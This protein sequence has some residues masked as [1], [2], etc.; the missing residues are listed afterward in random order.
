[1]RI[2][3]VK[4]SSL[5][6]IV[7]NLPMISDIRAHR[8]LATIDWLVEETF[9]DIP[10][11]HPGVQSVIP[12][13]LRKWLRAPLTRTTWTEIRTARKTL[14]SA[15]YDLILDSQGLLKSALVAHLGLGPVVG[16]DRLSARETLAAHFYQRGVRVRWE[17]HAIWRNRTLAAGALGYPV[18]TDNPHYGIRT[19]PAPIPWPKPYCVALHGSSRDSKLWGEPHWLALGEALIRRGFTLLLPSGSPAETQRAEA[20]ASAM[21]PGAYALP[22]MSLKTLAGILNEAAMVVGVD[23][24][25]VHLAAALKRP[26]VGIFVDS[27]PMQTG[28]LAAQ[29]TCNLGGMGENPPPNSVL[30]AL[31]TLGVLTSL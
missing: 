18:P 4:T 14:R 25:L 11:L 22:R 15:P 28:V 24:G 9:A 12:I 3:V 8:P 27:D 10:T 5:G 1:M 17:Q 21:G 20:M 6:D 30:L 7:H 26:T 2:L 13:H 31:H 16:P 19:Q 23:T 29:T